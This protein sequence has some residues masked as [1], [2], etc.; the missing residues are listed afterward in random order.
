MC[1][2]MA[3]KQGHRVRQLTK[4]TAQA[5]YNTCYGLAELS[6]HLIEEKGFK[7]VC[8]GEFS[9]DP[10]EKAFS[11]FRQGSGGTYFINAQQVSEK[12]R[13]NKAKLHLQ[14]NHDQV[15]PG[16]EGHHQCND[17]NY[18]LNEEES[19]NFDQLP[20]LEGSLSTDVKEN[21]VYI[22]GY[23][24]RHDTSV[25]E[26]TNYYYEKYGG[27][28]NNVN[29]GGL[30]IPGDAVCQWVILCFIMFNIVRTK[31]CRKS[32][33]TIFQSIADH[34]IYGFSACEDFSR[35]L[36]NILINNYCSASTPRLGKES[37]QKIIKLL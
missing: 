3:G 25:A 28:T 32:L 37:K 20:E 33:M 31:I 9:T 1:Q 34:H 13:I 21:L 8:L 26:D 7:Y 23:V 22:A 4:D 11:K 36:A 5:M 2:A 12:L 18:A 17:C 14:L 24:A 30:K 6:K 35:T 27:Y 10:L 29:R 19:E 15:S 16:C